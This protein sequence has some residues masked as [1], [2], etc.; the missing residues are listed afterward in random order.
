[1]PC[2]MRRRRCAWRSRSAARISRC[3]AAALWP[4]SSP[5]A[6]TSENASR[7]CR[8]RS[9]EHTSELQS[10][11]DLVCRLLLEKK[12]IEEDLIP[13]HHENLKIHYVKTIDEAIQVSL[14]AGAAMPAMTM[15]SA[16][17]DDEQLHYEYNGGS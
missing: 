5:N 2:S 1:M 16:E 13:G 14:S 12:K 4:K 6:A 3:C 11:S 10:R 15:P 9:E 8:P 17:P 7:T